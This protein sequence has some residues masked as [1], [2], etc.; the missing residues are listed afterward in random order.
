[1]VDVLEDIVV[2]VVQYSYSME[3]FVCGAG[4]EFVVVIEVNSVEFKTI[5]TSALG[6]FMSNGSCSVV[7]KFS[8]R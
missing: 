8:K 2:M 4:T 3:P 1:M 5:E 7:S 6:E